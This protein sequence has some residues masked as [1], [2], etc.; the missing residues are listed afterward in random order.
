VPGATSTSEKWQGRDECILHARLRL[1]NE[2]PFPTCGKL[3]RYGRCWSG[4]A[5]HEARLLRHHHR[6]W[7]R[8]SRHH[9]TRT[10]HHKPS[11]LTEP[12]AENSDDVLAL[13]TIS[14][15]DSHQSLNVAEQLERF[16][17]MG[18]RLGVRMLVI[19]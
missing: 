18:Q 17:E 2:R 9:D 16:I 7:P 6:V 14:G 12:K 1:S 5:P 15:L 13:L 19:N 11:S 4:T 10:A 8:E 3:L